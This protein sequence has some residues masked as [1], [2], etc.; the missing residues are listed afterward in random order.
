MPED[1]L[2]DHMYEICLFYE[3]NWKDL[4]MSR[5]M[6]I[7]QILANCE[8]NYLGIPHQ[9]HVTYASLP[10]HTLGAY[11]DS[12]ACIFINQDYI[13][14]CTGYEAVDVIAHE[15]WHSYQFCQVALYDKLDEQSRQLYMF[16]LV[17]EYKNNFDNYANGEF[18]D[19]AEYWF[20]ACEITSRQHAED[21]FEFYTGIIEREVFFNSSDG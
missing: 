18:R 1:Y 9:L 3:D 5:R 13:K 2:S 16:D 12:D 15:C 6:E 17:R 20:Q 8:Q 10:K 14:T 11:R 4:D 7:M 19:S 21:A